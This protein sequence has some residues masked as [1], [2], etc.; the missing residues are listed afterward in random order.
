MN[1]YL[2]FLRPNFASKTSIKMKE[3]RKELGQ[4][5]SINKIQTYI[6]TGNLIIESSESKT[7]IKND[8]I[9]SSNPFD[10][11]IP[12]SVFVFFPI[13]RSLGRRKYEEEKS[14]M[15]EKSKWELINGIIYYFGEQ[16]SPKYGPSSELN[17]GFISLKKK[18]RNLPHTARNFNTIRKIFEI[19]NK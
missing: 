15:T 8:N 3:L 6:Q 12:K 18:I 4:V 5:K 11:S 10:S 1:K 2:I 19:A 14:K 9:I 7:L 13:G 16:C 17:S